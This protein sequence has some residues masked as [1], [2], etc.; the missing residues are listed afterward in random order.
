MKITVL[1]TFLLLFLCGCAS[2]PGWDGGMQRF[3]QSRNLARANALLESGDKAGAAR[4]LSAVADAA[5]VAG[6]TD[7]A[8]FR[9]A[10]LTIHPVAD[11]GGNLH[12]INLLKR[13]KKEYP[14]SRWTVQSGQLLELL[15]GVEEL[16]RQVKSLKS[17]NQTLGSEVNELNRNIEQLKQLDQELEKR[18]R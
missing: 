1:T 15:S 6:V 3:T 4:E 11:S 16:R 13:M 7:E 10:L 12:A 18:R 9:L 2:F 17:Q 14:A 5:G 8:L